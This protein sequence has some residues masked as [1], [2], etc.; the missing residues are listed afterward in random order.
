M[1]ISYTH[2]CHVSVEWML[3]N[4][5]RLLRLHFFLLSVLSTCVLCAW[6]IPSVQL[7]YLCNYEFVCLFAPRKSNKTATSRL[8]HILNKSKLI[9]NFEIWLI[10]VPLI[11]TKSKNTTNL[12]KFKWVK[13]AVIFFCICI[14]NIH[15][16]II[17]ASFV[18]QTRIFS[19]ISFYIN[20]FDNAIFF[21]TCLDLTHFYFFF[22][23]FK[24][25]F[26]TREKNY[27]VTKSSCFLWILFLLDFF[28]VFAL[29]LSWSLCSRLIPSP[30]PKPKTTKTNYW[31]KKRSHTKKKNNT[32]LNNTHERIEI[33]R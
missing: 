30:K 6:Q 24:S 25:W 13:V 19:I 9:T 31:K 32:Q 26:K 28:F 15:T 3:M 27:F 21:Y 12:G 16:V 7:T 11:I 14:F 4:L 18:L 2:C 17:I 29:L 8:I 1:H 22:V 10:V 33:E 23:E 20:I 5:C